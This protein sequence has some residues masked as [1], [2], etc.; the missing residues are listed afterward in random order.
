M[1]KYKVRHKITGKEWGYVYN[2]QDAENIIFHLEDNGEDYT[3]LEI[4]KIET[5]AKNDNSRNDV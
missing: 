3:Q 5:E 1:T 2:M 4:I